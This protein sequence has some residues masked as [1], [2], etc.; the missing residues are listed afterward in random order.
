MRMDIDYLTSLVIQ[1]IHNHNVYT[2]MTIEKLSES[3]HKHLSGFYKRKVHIANTRLNIRK[4]KGEEVSE[5]LYEDA[6][7]DAQN[8]TI[9]HAY[10][11]AAINQKD[12]ND[13]KEMSKL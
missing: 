8:I 6:L 11:I 2:E 1:K 12:L 4:M 7:A 9:R 3:V 13:L 5:Q 10:A